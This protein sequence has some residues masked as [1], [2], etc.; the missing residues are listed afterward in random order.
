MIIPKAGKLTPE[1]LAEV[2]R[3]A[4]EFDCSILEIVGRNRCIYAILGD[5]GRE[6]MFNRLRGLDY[7]ARVDLIESPYKSMDR[8]SALAEHQ[9]KVGE[10]SVGAGGPFFIGGHCTVD[11]EE[12]NLYLET[13]AALKE[14][15]V[16]AL[17]GGVWK[18]RTNPYSYQ[19]VS[20][21]L[22]IVLE[23]KARTGL[24]VDVEVMDTEQLEIAVD[25]G[26]DVLQIGTRNALNYSLLKEVGKKTTGSSTAVLLKR[27]RHMAPPN[28]FIAAAEYIVAAG[29]PNV[30]LCPRGTMPA[31]DG[32]R[33]QPDESIT[34][35][36][37]DKTWAP[38]VV[39]PSHSVGRDE[40]VTACSMAAV[41]YGADGLCIEA[42]IDPS[43][44]I[45]DDPKQA[46]TPAAFAEIMAA[47]RDIWPR[48]YQPDPLG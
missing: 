42:H 8:K 30:M 32:Y 11:P 40:Y 41:A 9:V 12:P 17:R 27:G 1:Q 28:E 20:K 37:K 10:T 21:A 14:I 31:L 7:L 47:C 46:V 33:N 2:E 25:A 3:I 26:V 35:L 22:E 13:A 6:L 19:G 15:G 38:V 34:P 18:P 36:L 43:K 16:H 29:N 5:E 24:P 39:D 23:A 48:R 4:G 45:G 44:G